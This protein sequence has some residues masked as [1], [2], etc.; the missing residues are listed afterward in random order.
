MD[1]IMKACKSEI[2]PFKI[3]NW[4]MKPVTVSE[5]AFADNL[6]LIAK[7]EEDLQY[8]LNIWNREFIKKNM[9]LNVAKTETMI[10]REEQKH[11][12]KLEGQKLQQVNYFKYLGSTIS[13]DG[14]VDDEIKNRTAATGRLY[15]MI[16]KSFLN[17]K[18]ISKNTK[19]TVYKTIYMPTLT[20]GCESWPMTSKHY[21]WIQTMEMRYL[22]KVQGKTKRD[23]IRNQT[24]RMGLGMAPLA[25]TIEEYRAMGYW[26]A[27]GRGKSVSL[28]EA[29]DRG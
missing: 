7:S 1:E 16:N 10:S 19:L 2:R 8:N 15:H 18:E 26:L 17:K 25:N 28:V 12:I 23:R 24:I 11:N 14:R 27:V 5:L 9:R 3:G 22:R 21:S 29:S 6:V 20:Y 13:H 4:L